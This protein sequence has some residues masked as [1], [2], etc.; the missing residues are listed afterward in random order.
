V[1]VRAHTQ[2]KSAAHRPGGSLQARA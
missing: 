2:A 1:R